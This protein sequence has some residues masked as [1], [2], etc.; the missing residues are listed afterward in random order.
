MKTNGKRKTVTRAA[1]CIDKLDTK[2]VD[3]LK[4]DGLDTFR[5]IQHYS[6]YDCAKVMLSDGDNIYISGWVAQG[7]MKIYDALKPENQEK[8]KQKDVLHLLHLYE[9]AVEGGILKVTI[10]AAK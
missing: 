7:V 9:K 10:G 6:V 3:N 8:M 2:V 4:E 5:L 1:N